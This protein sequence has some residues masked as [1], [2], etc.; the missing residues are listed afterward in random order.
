MSAPERRLAAR[1]WSALGLLAASMLVARLAAQPALPVLPPGPALDGV[2]RRCLSCHEVDLIAQQRLSR[3]GW[4]RE[5]EKM[6]RWGAAV[7]EP[8]KGPMIEYLAL[9]F[10]PARAA[11][12]PAAPA[13]TS[14][15]GEKIFR[16]RC[17]LCHEADLSEQQ[18]LGRAGWEREVDK[19]VRW[20]AVVS[21]DEKGPLVEF[22][23]SR[24]G[25]R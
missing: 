4:T 12:P 20:G 15:R 1:A 13:S 14:S 24:Y 8:E 17:L 10:G 18:R 7:P 21:P 3:A 16:A 11:A 23:A 2:R 25:P 22:L 9:Q 6:V 19:M 5:V